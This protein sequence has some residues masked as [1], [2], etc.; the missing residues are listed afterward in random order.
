MDHEAL[1]VVNAKKTGAAAVKAIR[2][3][4]DSLLRRKP[5]NVMRINGIG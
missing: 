2:E 4:H 3:R 5:S 1:V